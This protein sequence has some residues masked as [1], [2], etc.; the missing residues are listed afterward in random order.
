M[1]MGPPPNALLEHWSLRCWSPIDKRH[2]ATGNCSHTNLSTGQ[3][4]P[5]PHYVAIAQD[6]GVGFLL[7]HYDDQWNFITDTWHESFDEAQGQA[8]FEFEGITDTWILP[9]DEHTLN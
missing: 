5:V 6:D 1:N 4:D 7:L 9:Q 8:E 3:D 2:R